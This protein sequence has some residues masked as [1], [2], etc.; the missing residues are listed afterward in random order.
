MA[1]SE[2]QIVIIGGGPAGLT[3]ALYAA[4]ADLKPLVIVGPTWGGLLQQ[5]TE[6]E[7]FP[8][9][10]N[11]VMGPEM[12]MD[13]RLQAERFGARIR[14]D[15]AGSVMLSPSGDEHH[16]VNVGADQIAAEALIVAL[17]ADHRRLGVAGEIELMGRGVSY[18]ATC[19]AAFFRGKHVVV[20][21]GGDSAM[22]EAALV[23]RF[24][25]RV[26]LVHRRSGFR[27]SAIM[28]DRIR[29]NPRIEFLAPYQ[30]EEFVAGDA[31]KLA[32]LRLRHSENGSTLH[33]PAEGAFVAIGHVPQ[34]SLLASQVALDDDGYVVVNGRTSRTSVPGVFAAGDVVDKTYRQAVTAAG[35]GCQAALDATRYLESKALVI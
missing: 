10:P 26:T 25:E 32:K 4:R 20:I 2:E 23:A 16:L 27:A 1:Y 15:W 12:M 31:G 24:A 11:G 14:E 34:S 17:G 35:L 33:L 19:D 3:A 21:G 9:Y 5:T 18:C 29:Q 13:L 6:V 8:G 30:V 22:E 28:L 7:N